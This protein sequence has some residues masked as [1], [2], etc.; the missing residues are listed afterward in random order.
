MFPTTAHLRQDLRAALS[1]TV[2]SIPQGIAY[3][4][5]A[6]M[7]PAAGLYAAALPTVI[8]SLLRSSPHVITGPT[9]A[10]SLLVGAMIAQ[11]ADLDPVSAG[12]LLALIVGVMQ[13]AAGI[14]RLGVLVDYISTAV[15]TGY[16]TGA[17]VLIAAG[18]LGHLTETP[19]GSGYL[20]EQIWGWALS[21][22]TLQP[23]PITLGLISALSILAL[24]TLRPR[25][26]SE[27]LVIAVATVAAGLLH[28]EVRTLADL[29]GIPGGLPG[30]SLPSE[31][32]AQLGIVLPV[33]VA[34]SLLSLVESASV[35]RSLSAR[36]GQPLD[37]D[38]EFLGQGAANLVAG[39]AGAYPTSGSLTRS[40][41]NHAAGARTRTSGVIAG[42]TMLLIPTLAGGWLDGIPLPA[43]AG[44]LMVVAF[45]LVEPTRIRRIVESDREDALAFGATLMGTWILPLDRA[46]L[47]GV[48]ISLALFLRRARHL[49]ITEMRKVLSYV[50]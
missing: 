26:P 10:L 28:L 4:I 23:A 9:N 42:A 49:V 21:V 11:H 34:A 22:H 6:G 25:W 29:G 47:L 7:P 39:V 31:A 46:I 36:T 19:M 41:L 12:A 32:M 44:L 15:I 27:V 16:I 24:K 33:A 50:F 37:L 1:V 14:L 30:F 5:I 17:G 3:A 38:R 8:G 2:L 13:V 20:F 35:A 48:G 18:Q 43:L 45:S 40:A